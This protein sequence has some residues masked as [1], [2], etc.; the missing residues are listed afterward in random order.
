M[1]GKIRKS[2]FQPAKCLSNG[3]LQTLAQPFFR[4]VSQLKPR[5]ERIELPSEDFLDLDW[6]GEG[7]GPIV[8]VLHGMAGS[9]R[10]PY[11]NGLM[12]K[13]QQRGWRGVIM[14]Y[15]GTS[16]GP[17]RLHTHTHLGETESVDYVITTLQGREPNTPMAAVGCSMGANLLLKWEGEAGVNNTLRAAVAVSAPYDLRQ[18]SYHMR[19]GFSRLYQWILL[20]DLRNYIH[21]KY[22]Y[23]SR[24][25]A[26]QPGFD[27]LE[28][29]R[30]FWQFDEKITAPLHSFRDAAEYYLYSSSRS[31]LTEIT[32]PTL[33]IHAKD[34]PFMP[35][36]VI[37]SESELSD[38]TILELSEHGGH[39]GFIAGTLR[40]PEYWLEKRIP[41]FLEEYLK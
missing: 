8:L 24:P 23:R 28:T 36:S 14:Y 38:T 26:L 34:D 16:S 31:Y 13:I 29:I 39:V 1:A 12:Q 20:K 17:N 33:L 22:D 11:A 2:T 3:H 7:D 21:E 18:A 19:F 32:K 30:S 40:E 9:L 4:K 35:E 10:S 15:R 37:P 27:Q 25:K 6:V 5:R 41:E